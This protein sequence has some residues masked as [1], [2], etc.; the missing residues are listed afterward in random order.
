MTMRKKNVIW[1]I[2]LLIYLGMV[3]W[4]CFGQFESLPKVTKDFLG[5]PADKIVHFIMFLPFPFLC[6]RTFSFLAAKPWQA[7]LALFVIFLIGCL[8]AA[9][10]EIGQ[11]FTSHRSADPMDFLADA[12][13][14]ATCALITLILHLSCKT[15]TT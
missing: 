1:L 12:I 13:A 5:I 15:K 8:I 11:S 14:L 2:L 7:V 4:C 10:T 9:G 3:A 6:F